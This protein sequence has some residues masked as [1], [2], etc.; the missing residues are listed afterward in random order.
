MQALGER[1]EQGSGLNS[2]P[3]PFS[4]SRIPRVVPHE[5]HVLHTTRDAHQRL[6]LKGRTR[7]RSPFSERS[8]LGVVGEPRQLVLKGT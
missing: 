4:R 5:L 2:R 7:R 8:P 3:R 6:R 1:L